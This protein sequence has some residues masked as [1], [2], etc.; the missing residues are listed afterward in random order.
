MLR[1]EKNSD[2]LLKKV[3][4]DILN[5]KPYIPGKPVEEVERE[6]GLSKV[7][8]LASNENPLGPSPKAIQAIQDNAKKVNLYP[9]G[10]CFYLKKDLALHLGIEADNIIV[11]N[12]SDEIVSIISRVFIQKGDEA[13]MGD[14]SFLMYSIDTRLS[15]GNVVS[16]PL[17]DFRLDARRM[18]EAITYKTKVIFISNPNNP[19]GTIIG[20][21]EM[22]EIVDEV[23]SDVLIVCD[24]AYYEYVDAPD[25]PDTLSWVKQGKN[26]V[27]LRTFSK[28]YGLAGL[29]VGYGIARK[30]IISILNRARPPFNVNSLAQV[31]ARVS[32]QDNEHVI[33]GKNLTGQGKKFLYEKLRQLGVLF[34]PTQANFILIEAGEKT[35]QIVLALL[36]KGIIVRDMGAYNLPHYI[37]L[38]IGRQEENE[39]FIR[40]FQKALQ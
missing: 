32:L 25:Y 3:P 30:G 17:I 1:E 26:I 10:G 39:A 5:V 20:K 36:R 23:P 4:M 15:Q 16:V 14:P 28:I 34:I 27:V 38:T 37:R 13:I 6:L 2:S 35:R 21:D 8:K 24:E 9:D 19:T 7:I 40:E 31:A 22:Q 18:I 29:R 11:G 33:S 12:G